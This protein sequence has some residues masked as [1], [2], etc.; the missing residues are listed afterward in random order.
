MSVQVTVVTTTFQVYMCICQICVS[1]AEF[2]NFF[3]Y[4]LHVQYIINASSKL[5]YNLIYISINAYL[6][7]VKLSIVPEVYSV[8]EVEL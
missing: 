6:A 5:S 4:N 1:Y 2:N 7:Q 8:F 3:L